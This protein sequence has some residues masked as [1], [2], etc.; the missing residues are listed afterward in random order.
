[1]Q[2]GPWSDGGLFA[3]YTSPV[4]GHFDVENV[5]LYNASR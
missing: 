4:G 1:M 3:L 5:L 2:E